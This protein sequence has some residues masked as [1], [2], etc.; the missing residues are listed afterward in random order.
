MVDRAEIK[1]YSGT[2]ILNAVRTAFAKCAGDGQEMEL[3]ANAQSFSPGGIV[4]RDRFW[5]KY[6]ALLYGPHPVLLDRSL[7]C[8]RKLGITAQSQIDVRRWVFILAQLERVLIADVLAGMPAPVVLEKKDVEPCIAFQELLPWIRWE[9]GLDLTCSDVPVKNFPRHYLVG[10]VEPFL[11]EMID[12]LRESFKEVA[13]TVPYFSEEAR[14]CETRMR[15]SLVGYKPPLFDHADFDE[16]SNQIA[17]FQDRVTTLVRDIINLVVALK[18]NHEQQFAFSHPSLS[19]DEFS[20]QHCFLDLCELLKLLE[21][22]DDVPEL[23]GKLALLVLCAYGDQSF[24]KEVRLSPINAVEKDLTMRSLALL[25]YAKS[26]EHAA[27]VLWDATN[28]LPI[29]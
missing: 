6:Q 8:L 28:P 2:T 7:A 22:F 16:L 3:I 11:E 14:R 18:L 19:K 20:S 25:P 5:S 13:F 27:A 4:L 12:E 15:L 10:L 21:Q 9:K 17:F 1:A 26:Y 23:R 29:D 24:L